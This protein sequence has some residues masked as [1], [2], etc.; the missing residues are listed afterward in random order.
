MTTIGRRRLLSTI[1][2]LGSLWPLQRLL[3]NASGIEVGDARAASRS[4]K[5]IILCSSFYGYCLQDFNP[6][7]KPDGTLDVGTMLSPLQPHAKDILITLGVTHKAVSE[8]GATQGIFTGANMWDPKASNNFAGRGIALNSLDQAFAA[9]Q[10]TP[11]KSV[12]LGIRSAQEGGS[13]AGMKYQSWS[14]FRAPI[15][16]INNPIDVLKAVQGSASAMNPEADRRAA[17][18][19]RIQGSILDAHAKNVSLLRPKLPKAAQVA[20]DEHLAAIREIERQAQNVPSCV[21]SP[22]TAEILNVSKSVNW[23]SYNDYK[24]EIFKYT[25]VLTQAQIG[26]A[27]EALACDVTRCVV[28]QFGHEATDM[29]FPWLVPDGLRLFRAHDGVQHNANEYLPGKGITL[30][31]RWFAQQLSNLITDLKKKYDA[32]GESIFDNTLL[33]WGNSMGRDGFLH[34]CT[35]VPYIM[36][37]GKKWNLGGGRILDTRGRPTNDLIVTLG[38]IMGV[39]TAA[40]QAHPNFKSAISGFANG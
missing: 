28:L 20:M 8:H 12:A 25:P 32:D 24:A 10:D 13:D 26:I 18:A 7:L 27:V 29:A 2:T 15:P 40:Y 21:F 34:G 33:V 35:D 17:T 38:Q 6:S 14:N 4:K 22:P 11:L 23:L 19:R 16:P 1:G 36:V 39:D 30:I 3:L 9:G 31:Q 5:R 37:A